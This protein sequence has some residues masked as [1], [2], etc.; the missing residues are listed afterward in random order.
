MH[1]AVIGET[2]ACPESAL[3][4]NLWEH[5]NQTAFTPCRP[6][7]RPTGAA[8]SAGPDPELR[9]PARPHTV[10][11]SD[12]TQKGESPA[13]TG[14][15]AGGPY[16]APRGSRP[17]R[18][19]VPDG[20]RPAAHLLHGE[21]DVLQDAVLHLG[22]LHHSRP[23]RPPPPGPPGGARG[24]RSPPGPLPAPPPPAGRLRAAGCPARPRP[25]PQAAGFGPPPLSAPWPR[26]GPAGE[27]EGAEPGRA[28]DSTALRRN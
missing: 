11:S 4:Q 23:G 19:A 17:G 3:P 2:L 6:S 20:R 9:I 21:R 25:G 28:R 10:S 27:R 16:G 22:R 14:S 1:R 8:I 15:P 5:L 26:P 24:P 18:P 7:E 13:W 12:R